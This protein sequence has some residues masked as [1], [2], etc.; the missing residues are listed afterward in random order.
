MHDLDTRYPHSDSSK[1]TCNHRFSGVSSGFIC[2]DIS[3]PITFVGKLVSYHGWRWT[4]LVGFYLAT[5]VLLSNLNRPRP[6]TIAAIQHSPKARNRR[7]YEPVVEDS[8][9]NLVLEVETLCFV[10]REAAVSSAATVGLW[11]PYVVNGLEI[12]AT[13]D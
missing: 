9:E 12:Y 13:V 11:L 7:K 1:L 2:G 8:M 5:W 3:T 4:K 6:S 10:L